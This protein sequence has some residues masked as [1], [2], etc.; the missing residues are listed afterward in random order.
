MLPILSAPARAEGSCQEFRAISQMRLGFA[1]VPPPQLSLYTW[2]GPTYVTLGGRE[3][4]INLDFVLPPGPPPTSV[5]HGVVGMDRGVSTK[6]DFGSGG[7]LLLENKSP[8]VYPVP[9][10]KAGMG[11]YR[12]TWRI[13]GGTGRFAQATGNIAENGPYLV[14]FA[15]PDALLPEGRY[16][17]ELSGSIC[18]VLP[19]TAQ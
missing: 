3:V 9:P 16:N 5:Q 1:T 2:T 17:G 12:A 10:G 18:N 8:G 15:A 19:R 11:Y 6:F 14:W 13:V 4:V 7:T